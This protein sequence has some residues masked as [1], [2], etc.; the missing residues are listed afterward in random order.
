MK[1][2]ITDG[3]S[4]ETIT[5]I[6]ALENEVV[7]LRA[8]VDRL[9][10]M[11]QKLQ[12]MQ[13]GQ[14][15]EKA[16]Y[17]LGNPDQLSFF[18]EAEV[19]ADES[20]P[21]PEVVREHT[22]KPKRT[23][24]ELARDLPVKKTVIELPE[25]KRICDICE[26][27]LVPIGQ[28]FVRRELNIIPAQVF[29]E[30]IYRINY[31]CP[32]CLEETDEANIIKAPVPEP[33]VKRGLA[34]PSSVAY[35]LYQKFQN[36]MPLYRQEEDWKHHGLSLSRATLANWIIYVCIHWFQPLYDLL[37]TH[38]LASPVNHADETVIQVLKEDGKTPQSESRM[39]VYATG[40]TGQPPVILFEYQPSRS[41]VHAKN[42]LAGF[43][44]YL[45]TDGYIGYSSV[46]DVT[47]C[48][49]WQHVRRKWT[50]AIPK[51]KDKQGKALEGFEFCERLF[52]LERVFVNMTPEE[53][54]QE[55]QKLSKPVLEAYF[56][57]LDSVDPLGGSRLREA[58]VYSRNQREPLSAFLLDGRIEISNN[59]AENAIRPFCVG[60]KNFL[61]ADTVR[62]AQSS[63]IAYSIVESAKANSL[64]PYQYLLHLLTELPTVLAKDPKADLSRFLPWATDLPM[65]CRR[66]AVPRLVNTP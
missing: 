37:K 23:K 21:E 58:V 66:D 30:E 43:S 52:A 63:A 25:E 16:K 27:Q 2:M 15:S 60:R 42:F 11:L 54:W 20:A 24:E 10:E 49:C 64:N 14:S 1:K 13:F 3:L 55:R 12:K 18:N 7:Q 38:L 8:H 17:V 45:V 47:H 35:T 53:R 9:T 31:A 48:G 57:W 19:C 26:G 39:W 22:R 28:E 46:P 33:V 59:R 56:A 41:G 40:N 44:G 51:T 34:S 65:R 61:F 36:A 50:D 4:P 29:V 32:P 5:Y 62:G 6:S